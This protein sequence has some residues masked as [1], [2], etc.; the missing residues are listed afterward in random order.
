[1]LRSP[2]PEPDN[3]HCFAGGVRC[4]PAALLLALLCLL[5]AGGTATAEEPKTTPLQ[6]HNW[7]MEAD[8]ALFV[9]AL[10]AEGV[11]FSSLEYSAACDSLAVLRPRLEKRI[12]PWPY[13]APFNITA[14]PMITILII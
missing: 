2:Q 11:V 12:K 9:E 3:R 1:M 7:W 5:A 13:T 8:E 10:A 14:G 4:L 6:F